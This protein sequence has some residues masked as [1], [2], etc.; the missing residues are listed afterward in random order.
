MGAVVM[1]GLARGVWKDLAEVAALRTTDNRI[2]PQMA[3]DE[4]ARLYAGWVGAV[5]TVNKQ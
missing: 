5:R 3:D 2:L 4:R 1:N